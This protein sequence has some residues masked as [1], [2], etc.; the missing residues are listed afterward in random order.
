MKYGQKVIIKNIDYQKVRKAFESIRLVEFLT[1][2][3]P[4]KIIEWSGIE[5]GKIAYF[6]LWFFGWRNFKVAH[7]EYQADDNHLFFVDEGIDLP[8]GISSWKHNHRV[9][10]DKNNTIIEDSLSFSHVNNYM[11]YILFPILIFPILIRKILYRIYF[12]NITS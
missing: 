2:L 12:F 9:I 6:K 11:G 8:L 7:T 10:K 4:I 5:V 1:Y 3:Q